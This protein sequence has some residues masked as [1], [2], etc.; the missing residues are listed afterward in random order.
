MEEE[1]KEEV[2]VETPVD[3]PVVPTQEEKDEKYLKL[4]KSNNRKKACIII[5]LFV[6]VL[7]GL[8]IFIFFTDKK[9][10]PK[11]DDNK[12]E[13]KKE[14]PK[15]YIVVKKGNKVNFELREYD[16]VPDTSPTKKLFVNGKEIDES[17]IPDLVG[18]FEVYEIDDVLAVI[19]AF[20]HQD[21]YFLSS[22]GKRI[23]KFDAK[24]AAP[25]LDKIDGK[26]IYVY[27]FGSDSITQYEYGVCEF[28]DTDPVYVEEKMTYL[29][30]NQFSNVQTLKTKTKAE[31]VKERGIDCSKENGT[32]EP[33]QTKI[34]YEVKGTALYVNNK[35]V[36]PD[37]S[38]AFSTSKDI[39]FDLGDIILAGDCR[40]TCDWYFID[41]TA[42][43]V[44]TLGKPTQTTVT[45]TELVK[46]KFETV[47]VTKVESK[48]IYFTDYGYTTQ[49][50]SSICKYG[51]ND[52]VYVQEKVTY[53]GNK[54]FGTASTVTSKTK[55]Q[56]MKEDQRFVCE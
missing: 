56:V 5:L 52:T 50:G 4:K 54:T 44:G 18:I 11:K 21:I 28:K 20:D 25:G 27:S 49:D 46:P 15:D 22:E 39:V 16:N 37:G 14:E 7:A 55:A 23:G 2:V 9:E 47:D 43:V 12:Q 51:E 13:E 24:L 31:Y 41:T 3:T 34:S 38:G 53:N 40:S 42:K 10:E 1:K 19:V 26:D 17:V 35:K 29:G 48:T 36:D 45:A 6:L 32:Q 30:N 33:A 8:I